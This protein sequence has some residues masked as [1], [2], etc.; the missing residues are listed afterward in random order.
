[1]GAGSAR[2]NPKEGRARDR[3][4]FMHRVYSAQRGI[5]TMVSDEGARPWGR[6]RSEFAEHC[7][8]EMIAWDISHHET[9]WEGRKGQGVPAQEAVPACGFSHCHLLAVWVWEYYELG[10]FASPESRERRSHCPCPARVIRPV[11]GKLWET[12]VPTGPDCTKDSTRA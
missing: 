6:G 11:C 8:C 9:L 12:L 7:Q 10:P 3:K 4:P 2:P 1:M 5:E